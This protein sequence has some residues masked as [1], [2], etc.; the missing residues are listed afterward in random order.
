MGQEAKVPTQCDPKTE[1]FLRHQGK[2]EQMGG[3]CHGAVKSTF[4]SG[5][6]HS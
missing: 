6:E 1:L 3:A 2:K 5:R 4:R